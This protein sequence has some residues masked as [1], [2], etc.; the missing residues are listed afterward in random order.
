MNN[1]KILVFMAIALLTVFFV[2]DTIGDFMAGTTSF[3]DSYQELT[4][5]DSPLVVICLDLYYQSKYVEPYILFNMTQ[6]EGSQTRVAD[7]KITK[8]E[9]LLQELLPKIWLEEVFAFGNLFPTCYKLESSSNDWSAMWMTNVE[10]TVNE[11]WVIGG[12][13]SLPAK[14][15]FTTEE[16]AHGAILHQ[17]FDGIVESLDLLQNHHYHFELDRVTEIN[18]VKEKCT[19]LPYYRCLGSVLHA[20]HE[21][22]T[23]GGLCSVITL[24][25]VELPACTTHE[26]LNCS[27]DVFWNIFS[28]SSCKNRKDRLC[29]EVSNDLEFRDYT[30]E[31]VKT[32][33]RYDMTLTYS[34][35][36]QLTLPSSTRGKRFNKA[37]KTVK[38]EYF[39][40]NWLTLT[41]QLGGILSMTLQFSFISALEFVISKVTTVYFA[42]FNYMNMK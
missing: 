29:H 15:F 40:W 30:F 34:F 12:G 5:Q 6:Q 27:R 41:A 32:S 13:K 8:Q 23:V 31:A 35:N 39:V 7:L 10:V 28:G 37:Y 16:N 4:D 24:P 38:T 20:S 21:C 1:L 9:T 26:A 18:L 25:G 22:E 17:F 33:D 3:G 14:V 42:F 11:S 2:Q 36:Y 19:K